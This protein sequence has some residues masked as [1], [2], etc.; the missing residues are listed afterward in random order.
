MEA[1]P[2]QVKPILTDQLHQTPVFLT[3]NSW[4]A[5]FNSVSNLYTVWEIPQVFFSRLRPSLSADTLS[6]GRGSRT[7]DIKHPRERSPRRLLAPSF[8]L[9]WR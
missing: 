5:L 6:R 3:P 2:L 1:I 9:R 4:G 7:L 8:C